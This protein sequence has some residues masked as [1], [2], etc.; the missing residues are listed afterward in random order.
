[1]VGLAIDGITLMQ[2]E[3]SF[4]KKLKPLYGNMNSHHTRVHT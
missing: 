2:M 3:N 4:L 1:M